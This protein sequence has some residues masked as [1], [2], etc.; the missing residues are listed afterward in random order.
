M[1]PLVGIEASHLSQQLGVLRRA[2]LVQSRKE[3]SSV[4]YTLRDTLDV[5]GHAEPL[6]DDEDDA[7]P[8]GEPVP[9]HAGA[10]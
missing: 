6:P 8:E 4:I 1:Q 7:D 2:G 3:G 9:A 5:E 10:E